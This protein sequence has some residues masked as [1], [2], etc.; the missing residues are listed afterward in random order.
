MHPIWAI[1]SL[2]SARGLFTRMPADDK[3]IYLTFDD[4]PDATHTLRVLDLLDAHHALAT[5]FLQGRRV[6]KHRQIASEIVRRGHSLGN[7]SYS[8]A[9]FTKI[10]VKQQY[11]EISRTDEILEQIDGRQRHLLRPPHGRLNPFTALVCA[12]RRQRI[13]LWT[14]DS[15]DHRLG[16]DEVVEQLESLDMRSGDILLFHDDGAAGIS[17][18]GR[19]LPVW[20]EA[21][22]V[23]SKL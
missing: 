16:A 23:F 10:G 22:F 19:M 15:L 21:G 4:G 11:H 2:L 9:S 1:V 6:E 7:H 3:T 13:A 17:A 8:H 20:R 12:T 18:L 14:H 5:F